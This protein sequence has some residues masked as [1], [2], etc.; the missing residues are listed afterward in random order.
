MSSLFSSVLKIGCW[1]HV[2][3]GRSCNGSLDLYAVQLLDGMPRF[4]LGMHNE[5]TQIPL[6]LERFL[7]HTKRRVAKSQ[8]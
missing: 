3:V 1:F 6:C 7:N 4:K 5:T 2:E 8:N